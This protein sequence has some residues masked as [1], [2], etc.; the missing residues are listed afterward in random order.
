[1][2]RL[3][4]DSEV[5]QRALSALGKEATARQ[6]GS[7]YLQLHAQDKATRYIFRSLRDLV[8]YR[9]CMKCGFAAD[10]DTIIDEM[11]RVLGEQALVRHLPKLLLSYRSL[12]PCLFGSAG[13]DSKGRKRSGQKKKQL[14]APMVDLEDVLNGIEHMMSEE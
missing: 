4:G 3:H 11:G 13:F 9:C 5:M 10:R 8:V 7:A 14:K 12:R 1:M 2:K 6:A